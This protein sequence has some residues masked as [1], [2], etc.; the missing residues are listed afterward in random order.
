MRNRSFKQTPR[1]ALS[2]VMSLTVAFGSFGGGTV[3]AENA[4]PYVPERGQDGRPI[5]DGQP[6]HLT[7][8]VNYIMDNDMSVEDLMYFS[9]GR[10]VEKDAQGNNIRTRTVKAGYALPVYLDGLD[11][12][13]G[14]STD[15]PAFIALGNSWNPDLANRVGTVIGNEKRGTV[16]IE[17]GSRALMWSAIG[18]IRNNPLS[19]RY[20]EGFSEDPLLASMLA[21]SMGSGITGVDLKDESADNDF[22]LKTGIQSKHYAVYNAQW[23]RRNASNNVSSRALHEYQLPTF[24]RQ[25]EN[26]SVV[27][28]MTSYGRTN[29]VPNS[30][31]PN[32][33]IAR[34]VSPYSVSL[35]TDFNAIVEMVTAMGNGKDTTYVP[36]NAHSSALLANIA[37]TW[38]NSNFNGTPGNPNKTQSIDGMKRGLFGVDEAALKE[39]VRPILEL[40]VRLGYF[41]PRDEQGYP[42][43]YP[44]NALIQNPTNANDP[45]N[46]EVALQ[47]ARESI[48]LLKNNG[49]LPLDKSKELAV[50]GQ[51]ANF[52]NKTLY[53]VGT[54]P[55]VPG[56]N[57]TIADAIK[58][59]VGADRVDV[60]SGGKLVAWQSNATGKYLTADL[61]SPNGLL[62]AGAEPATVTDATYAYDVADGKYV[63]RNEVFEIY[64]WGQ[65]AYSFTALANGKYVIRNP[66]DATIALNGSRPTTLL[67][68]NPNVNAVFSYENAGEAK[69]IRQGGFKGS[70]AGGFESSF[71]KDG[72]YLAVSG[73]AVTASTNVAAYKALE[74]K[75]SV[76][77]KEVVVQEVGA[78]AAELALSNDYAVVVIGAP[79]QINVSEGVDRAR[80]DMGVDQ[81]ALAERAAAAFK[82]Q[83]KKTIVVISTSYPVAMKELQ[84]NE[85]IDAIVF[86][87]YGGQYDGKALAEVLF[88]DVAPSGRLQSTWYSDLSSFPKISKYSLPEGDPNFASLTAVD[89]R[90]TVDMTNA[91]PAEA[92]LTYQYTDAEVTYPFGYGLSY[93]TF[94][95]SNLQA[96]D[97]VNADGTFEVKVDVTN[98][99]AVGASEVVQL[100][101]K[102][103]TSEYGAAVPK[104][105]L[106]AF[107]KEYIPA[108][109]TKTVTLKVDPKNFAI[110]DVNRQEHIVERGT[111]ALMVG[112]SSEDIVLTDSFT[113]NGTALG[114]LTQSEP[115]NVW[116]HAFVSNDVVYRE[117]SKERTTTYAGGYYAVMSTGSDSWVGLPKVDLNNAIGVKLRVASNQPSSSIAI[118]KDSPTGQTLATLTFGDTGE[119][120]YKVPSVDGS[121]ATL[122]EIGY[123]EVSASLSSRESGTANLYL[124]FD[125]PDIR[126]DSIQIIRTNPGT[127]G[128]TG[129]QI[130]PVTP[131]EKGVLAVTEAMLKRGSNKSTITAPADVKQLNVPVGLLG[132]LG[133]EALEISSDQ[134]T[135]TLPAAVLE[136]LKALVSGG[137]TKGAAVSITF[138][139]ADSKVKQSVIEKSGTKGNADLTLASELFDFG[140]SV[141]T[142]DGSVKRLIQ[143][144]EPITLSLKLTSNV[145]ETIAGI[146]YIADDGS[147]AYAGGEIKDGYMTADVSHFSQY[148]VLEVSKSFDDVTDSH[149]AYDVIRELAAKQVVNGTSSDRFEPNR[150][151]TRAEFTKLLVEALQLTGTGDHSF[152]DVPSHVWFAKAVSTAYGLGIVNG[153]SDT[154]FDPQGV[155]TREEMAVMLTRAY[156][157][158]QGQGKP[159]VERAYRD[160]DLISGWAKPYVTQATELGLVSGRGNGL[161][162]PAA[163]LTRAE[164]AKAVYN[165]LQ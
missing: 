12:V 18:D 74:D 70:F 49:T 100:Y 44:F 106:A 77:F 132:Q 162:A 25:I 26:G 36:D 10:Q 112:K 67:P 139:P 107:K 87:P 90:F 48:V 131:N 135:M 92:K 160:A 154:E 108:N 140:L 141:T 2:L 31:S 136:S 155:I 63:T 121:G 24:L 7:P 94:V 11:H 151:I 128:N 124:V 28:F 30:I 19:G 122:R 43:G 146:F 144:D 32:I 33:K 159:T 15:F 157:L 40:Y 51:F 35:I 89:P 165:L 114:T 93:T 47:A 71:L 138:T 104:K 96:P 5:F 98:N 142:A 85:N 103:T 78:E 8:F 125:Q 129:G 21:T 27:G 79:A 143:F 17:D 111:Y 120:T 126:V 29:G 39:A 118:K 59:V 56:A 41:N 60:R 4:A 133:N 9:N 163:A 13:Q 127:G 34:D 97:T 1:K 64:D 62:K 82:A 53:A 84:N 145:D 83:G 57:L 58:G 46:Q 123:S 80:L 72:N 22:Y 101:V 150:S 37:S 69:S 14:V 61:S 119:N 45:A 99:G 148:A 161:F 52:R 75:S 147:L 158:E 20:D 55:A 156:T 73:D 115:V 6:G 50:L 65:D 76:T 95:Y 102:N 116:D 16:A 152:S 3:S 42:I 137:D 134:V 91:D 88:G 130:P 54:T 81:V 68:F 23:F 109:E 153:K 66:A 113:V 149:W 38:G 164:A 117:V 86:A 110:W 105:Q